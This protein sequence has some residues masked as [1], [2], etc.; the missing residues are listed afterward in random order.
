MKNLIYI[1]I[2][3]AGILA[4]SCTNSKSPKKIF[5]INSYH[6]G[7][8]SSD[9]VMQ[10]IT[11][12]FAD[13]NVELK[14][15]F[16]DAKRKSTEEEMQHATQNA[17][18]EIEDFQPD[19]LIASDDNAMKYIIQPYFNNKKIPVVFCGVNWSAAQY[20]LGENVTGMLEVLPLR[21]C[22]SEI[23]A[24]YPETK[25]LVV[26]SENSL[27]EQ[28][29]KVL[30]DSLYRNLGLEITYSLADDFETW[31]TMFAEANENADLIYMPTNG[32]IKNWNVEEAK[33]IVE[34][35]KIPSITCD[36]FMMPFVV[37]V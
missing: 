22:I 7:Y 24:N 19:L 36:D 16:M 4:F 31:K 11:E 37:L 33:M 23:L 10:G 25:K 3:F 34:S 30:L 27:S 5:Y 12:T 21:E 20:N 2:F 6:P 14:T 17:L 32:T 15:F 13:K 29:N 1:L 35:L 9:D 8:G 28:N 26:L 18:K